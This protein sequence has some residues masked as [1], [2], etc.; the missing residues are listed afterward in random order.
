MFLGYSGSGYDRSEDCMNLNR[1]E[2]LISCLGFGIVLN[3]FEWPKEKDRVGS[4][5][6]WQSTK[7]SD[8]VAF[9]AGATTLITINNSEMVT[10]AGQYSM[11]QCVQHRDC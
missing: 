8:M 11:Q 2:A 10:F 3:S 7:A 6:C 5:L 1:Y 9:W 4:M